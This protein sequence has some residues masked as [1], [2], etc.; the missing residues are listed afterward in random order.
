MFELQNRSFDHTIHIRKRQETGYF[1]I[2][3]DAG[4]EIDFKYK[5]ES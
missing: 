5:K 1:I 2:T 3:N 4:K